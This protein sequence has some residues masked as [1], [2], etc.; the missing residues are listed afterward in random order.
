MDT[1]SLQGNNASPGERK[2]LYE[3][4]PRLVEQNLNNIS[5]MELLKD[6]E[7]IVCN[8]SNLNEVV[9]AFISGYKDVQKC[10]RLNEDDDIIQETPPPN[11]LLTSASSSTSSS[12]DSE[13]YE[14][15]D[16]TE[17]NVQA[18][19]SAL[20]LQ[21][22]EDIDLGGPEWSREPPEWK[23]IWSELKDL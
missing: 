13:A 10:N 8:C 2:L 17:I 1:L 16:C 5:A 21:R 4:V 6:D 9:H 14:D 22:D 23:N 3:I 7:E 11:M 12:K 20:L 18:L 15:E 19:K